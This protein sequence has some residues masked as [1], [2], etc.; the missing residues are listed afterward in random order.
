[1]A[2]TP[3][4]LQAPR[5]APGRLGSPLGRPRFPGVGAQCLLIRC[6]L[7]ALPLLLVSLVLDGCP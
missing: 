7:G 3:A 5:W 6:P 2:A 1:M 4:G